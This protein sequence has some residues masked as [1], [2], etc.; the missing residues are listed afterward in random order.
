MYKGKQALSLGLVDR[1]GTLADAI[2]AAKK[3]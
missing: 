2:K 1:L 3:S